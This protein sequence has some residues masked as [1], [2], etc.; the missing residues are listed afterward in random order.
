[1]LSAH[2]RKK[3]KHSLF[4]KY[5]SAPFRNPINTDG[6]EYTNLIHSGRY[7]LK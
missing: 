2:R 5:Y 1:M 6:L 7:T 4:K 3:E